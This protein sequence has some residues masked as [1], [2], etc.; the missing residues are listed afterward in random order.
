[1]QRLGVPVTVVTA[2]KSDRHVTPAH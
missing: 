2:K 1:V